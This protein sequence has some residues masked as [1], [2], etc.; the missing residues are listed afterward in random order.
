MY[1]ATASDGGSI[2]LVRLKLRILS[3]WLEL[4]YINDMFQ[5]NQ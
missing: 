5:D 4:T 2:G 3:L 1:S